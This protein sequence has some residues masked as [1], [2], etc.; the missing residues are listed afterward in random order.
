MRGC[1]ELIESFQYTE[2]KSFFPDDQTWRIISHVSEGDARSAAGSWVGINDESRY[3]ICGEQIAAGR[4]VLRSTFH[5]YDSSGPEAS[6]EFF[7]TI[8]GSLVLDTV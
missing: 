7:S 8:A 5:D 1:R 3:W 4:Q 2:L 6:W